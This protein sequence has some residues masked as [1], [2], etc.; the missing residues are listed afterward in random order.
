MS[1]L[2]VT[3]VNYQKFHDRLQMCFM[4]AKAKLR[5]GGILMGS[6]LNGRNSSIIYVSI[7]LTVSRVK[8]IKLL[9]VE[10]YLTLQ[11]RSNTM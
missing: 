4:P 5:Q 3:K 2:H 6:C 7:L 10:D 11:K 8:V 1:T 9:R